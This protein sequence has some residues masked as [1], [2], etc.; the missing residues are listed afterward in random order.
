MSISTIVYS[1]LWCVH[2]WWFRFVVLLHP[3]IQVIQIAYNNYDAVY[4]SSNLDGSSSNEK[5]V[6]VMLMI[7]L[8]ATL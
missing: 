2:A 3:E 5:R 1:I 8:S 6:F 4:Y 7:L